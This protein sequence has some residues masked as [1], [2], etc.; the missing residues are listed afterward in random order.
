MGM[1]D[2]IIINVEKLP[3]TEE[4]KTVLKNAVFQTKNLEKLLLL[5]SISDNGE[6]L[7]SKQKNGASFEPVFLVEYETIPILDNDSFEKT[8]CHG[9]LNFYTS[10]SSLWYEFEAKFTDDKL[11]SIK[12]ISKSTYEN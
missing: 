9:Y 1:F 4:E 8:P 6:L 12:R 10:I 5:Y 11:I 7:L 2:S 3:V